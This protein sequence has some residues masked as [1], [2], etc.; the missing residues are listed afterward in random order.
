MEPKTMSTLK[1]KLRPSPV[2]PEH[3]PLYKI[4]QVILTLWL[5]CRSNRSS[6]LRLH[7]FNWAMKSGER[8]Q[9]LIAASRTKKLNLVT[10]GFDPMLANALTYAKASDLVTSN[11]KGYELTDAG[12]IFAKD[13]MSDNQVL[14][15]EK[16]LFKEI[17]KSIT[18][19][20]V[21]DASRE[22]SLQ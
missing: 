22:W 20:M 14:T 3:R 11:A 10:W 16:E 5:A 8:R 19:G 17:G 4:S 9:Q 1:F 12:E 15:A 6:L 13:L 2:L 7:L 18:E 21:D